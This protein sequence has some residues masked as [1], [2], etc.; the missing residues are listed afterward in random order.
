MTRIRVLIRSKERL[1][2]WLYY[3]EKILL[4]MCDFVNK[5]T[6]FILFC[7]TSPFYYAKKKSRVTR[8]NFLERRFQWQIQLIQNG[9]SRRVK[10]RFNS[11]FTL[12]LVNITKSPLFC[13]QI[14]L[15]KTSRESPHTSVVGV[16]TEC[17]KR[18][19]GN[20][21]FLCYIFPRPC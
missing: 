11:V 20:S 12:Y 17:K 14:C 3:I 1:I 10:R 7:K 4:I 5:Y 19:D 18:K 9:K 6:L 2:L 8:L 15:Q 21:V 13:K 16:S